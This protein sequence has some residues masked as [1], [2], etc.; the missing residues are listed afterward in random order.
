MSIIAASVKVESARMDLER[1][2]PV[3]YAASGLGKSLDPIARELERIVGE[4]KDIGEQFR[5]L[6]HEP[7]E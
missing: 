6:I 4:L 1:A 7:I 2:I 3:V 5:D